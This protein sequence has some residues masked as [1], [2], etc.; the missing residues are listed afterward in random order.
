MA[1]YPSHAQRYMFAGYASHAEEGEVILLAPDRKV[2]NGTPI[3]N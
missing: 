1:G 2:P 3:A